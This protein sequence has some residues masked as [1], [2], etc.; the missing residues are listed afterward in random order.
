MLPLTGYLVFLICYS[1]TNSEENNTPNNPLFKQIAPEASGIDFENTIESTPELNILTYIYYYNGAGVATA[2]FNQDGLLDL[3]FTA[4]QGD[5]KLYLNQGAFK[6]KD[7]TLLAGISNATGWT[8]GV[9]VT[10]IN[11]DGRVD[12]YV[13]KVAALSDGPSHNLLFVNQGNDAQGIPTFKEDAASYQLDFSGYS[14][15]AAFFDYDL[16]GDLDCF[17]LNHATNPNQNYGRG[18]VRNIPDAT[19]GDKLLENQDGIFIDVSEASGIFQ[20]KIGYG[21][22]ISISDLNNDGYPDLYIS[23][24]FFENDYLYLS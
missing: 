9:T 2:D 5:D 13:S 11:N 7:I 15:Q 17:L 23:N 16:D 22:G 12:I 19:S 6:F 24:D 8:T 18:N 21:L 10:D 20:S 1:C 14:T 4:N 3:Y